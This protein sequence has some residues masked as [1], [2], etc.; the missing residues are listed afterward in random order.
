[1]KN[2]PSLQPNMGWTVIH[3]T[4]LPDF[5]KMLPRSRPGSPRKWHKTG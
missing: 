1:M 5:E 4:L 3:L 2:E